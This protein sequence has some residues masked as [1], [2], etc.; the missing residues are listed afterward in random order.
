MIA[1]ENGYPLVTI[2]FT[3]V[4]TNGR[5]NSFLSCVLIVCVI[6][7]GAMLKIQ[8]NI[9]RLEAMKFTMCMQ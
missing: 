3:I 5:I 6:I 7:T 2:D 1:I 8:L 4:S 9:L